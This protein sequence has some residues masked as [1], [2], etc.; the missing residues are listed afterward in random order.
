MPFRNDPEPKKNSHQMLWC[1]KFCRLTR[2]FMRSSMVSYELNHTFYKQTE[3][4]LDSLDG[5]T[6]YNIHP[7]LLCTFLSITFHH[8]PSHSI[9]FHYASATKTK[10]QNINLL[11]PFPFSVPVPW[12]G[13]KK[14]SEM[15]KVTQIIF[16]LLFIVHQVHCLK[17]RWFA[18]GKKPAPFSKK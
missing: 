12:L 3:H 13:K 10:T 7:F 1:T 18:N 15:L 4:F 16:Y 14:N 8:I 6:T 2:N 9:T 11:F 17:G 5:H